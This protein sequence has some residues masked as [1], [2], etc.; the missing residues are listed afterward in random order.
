MYGSD[1]CTLQTIRKDSNTYST[2]WRNNS[3]LCMS[4]MCKMHWLNLVSEYN[5]SLIPSKSVS[6]TIWFTSFEDMF[7]FQEASLGGGNTRAGMKTQLHNKKILYNGSCDDMLEMY[8]YFYLLSKYTYSILSK[9]K[10]TNSRLSI[11]TTLC[12][13]IMFIVH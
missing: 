3:L 11:I 13:T 12:L 10:Y 5:L 6:N 7:N 8:T 4:C 9:E 2:K 1:S